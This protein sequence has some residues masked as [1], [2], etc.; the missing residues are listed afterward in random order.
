MSQEDEFR[1]LYP[2]LDECEELAKDEKLFQFAKDAGL[3]PIS[4][5]KLSECG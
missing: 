4:L 3:L 2:E 5:S 1:K